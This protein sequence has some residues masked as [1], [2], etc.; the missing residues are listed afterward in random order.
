MKVVGRITVSEKR[1]K[2]EREITRELYFKLTKIGSHTRLVRLLTM[3][4]WGQGTCNSYF[5]WEK[6][7]IQD[8]EDCARA[9]TQCHH[10]VEDHCNEILTVHSARVRTVTLYASCSNCF[11]PTKGI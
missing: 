2:S 11:Y 7:A 5:S 4:N 6:V 3:F 1:D 8:G 9:V 10:E